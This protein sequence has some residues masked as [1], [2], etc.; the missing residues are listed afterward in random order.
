MKLLGIKG[1]VVLRCVILLVVFLRLMIF[2]CVVNL[3]IDLGSMLVM[4]W[5]GIL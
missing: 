3:V 4:V 5:F 2:L 1:W